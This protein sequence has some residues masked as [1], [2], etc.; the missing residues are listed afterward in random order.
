[1]I[2]K[3]IGDKRKQRELSK[4][5]LTQNKTVFMMTNLSADSDFMRP[6]G[7]SLTSDVLG[8][9]ASISRSRYRLKA[10]AALRAKTIH[11]TTSMNLS[12]VNKYSFCL[13][14][15]VNPISAKGKAKI[16]WLNLYQGQFIS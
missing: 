1:M 2:N 15:K 7:I 13:I 5:A 6:L 3:A 10:M 4:D 14:A 12:Q 16:V 9:L 8:F 11:K